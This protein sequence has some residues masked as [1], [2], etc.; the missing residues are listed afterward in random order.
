MSHATAAEK[1]EPSQLEFNMR[2]RIVT[3]TLSG[4]L[5][6]WGAGIASAQT[7]FKALAS[8]FPLETVKGAPGT[9]AAAEPRIAKT[10]SA[11]VSAAPGKTKV[12]V[13]PILLWVPAFTATTTVPAFPDLP[14]GPDLPGGSG[15]TSASFDGAAL[16][17]I[18]IEKSIWRV[19]ADGIWAALTTKRDR[20][21]LNVD[22]DVIYGH[23]SGGVKIYKELYAT[24]GVRRLALKYDIQLADRPQ[25]F[26]RKPGIWDPLV[27]LAWRGAL[28]SRW[29]LHAIGEGGGFG[30]GAD[31]DLAGTFRAD[32]Q[33]ARHVGL[34][35]GYSVLYLKLS[36]TALQRTFEVKQ[37]LH[38]PIV[39]VGLYF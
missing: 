15:S 35:L 4:V 6:V 23:V 39:G 9:G 10:K 36:D 11:D 8:A 31:V 28:G 5:A 22:M 17:G 13:Y 7:S 38:G 24:A 12:S 3:V 20:P 16:A 29:M 33:L 1:T 34:N 30:V 2:T 26:V 21:L 19:D 18:S 37:T 32:M 27:G 25:H 14:N